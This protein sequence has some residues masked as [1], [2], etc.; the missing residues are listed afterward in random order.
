MKKIIKG[1][2][3]LFLTAMLLIGFIACKGNGKDPAEVTVKS[4]AIKP[5]KVYL[6]FNGSEELTAIISPSNAL[7]KT[8][9]WTSDDPSIATVDKDGTVTAN[10]KIGSTTITATVAGKKATCS[11]EVTEFSVVKYSELDDWFENSASETEVNHIII[12]EIPKDAFEPMFDT[13]YIDNCVLGE[14]L[15][16]RNKNIF[17]EG[18]NLENNE[19]LTYIPSES[20]GEIS[21]IVGIKFPASFT[22]IGSHSFK[23]CRSLKTVDLSKCT[24]L[25]LIRDSVFM[26]C[27]ELKNI[28]LPESLREIKYSAFENCKNLTSIDLS[29]CT[30]L[31]LI[32][33]S[34][35][36]D[37]TELKNINLPESLEEIEYRA[38]ENCKNLTSIDLSKCESLR[39]SFGS[40]TFSGCTNA[41]V[42]LPNK[43]LY[44]PIGS[45][46]ENGA[47]GDSNENYCKEV[48]CHSSLRQDII[49]S[50][51][52]AD[53]ITTY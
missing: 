30:S 53:R 44:Y 47:F 52:P 42:K 13:P 46:L 18:L 14:A 7:N 20:F 34:V 27:T 5:V 41:I 8:V 31:E 45:E 9:T 4:V 17:I 39:P 11:V 35:F 28:N 49:D 22:S 33:D 16:H 21:N 26:D 29:K 6:E 40:S 19:A 3:L 32:G 50:G 24:S 43:H 25:E 48:H 15:Y 51:Y 38:F 37:C 2:S 1:I 12:T 36:M 23:K 10:S